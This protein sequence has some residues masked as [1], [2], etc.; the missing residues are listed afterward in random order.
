[1]LSS[2]KTL[3]DKGFRI[4]SINPLILNEYIKHDYQSQEEI[5]NGLI[6]QLIEI[7]DYIYELSK[8][9]KIVKVGFLEKNLIQIYKPKVI[10]SLDTVQC[11]ATSRN[12]AINTKGDVFPCDLF[13]YK[14]KYKLGNLLENKLESNDLFEKH[15]IKNLK[16]EY[17]VAC[18]NCYMRY[19]CKGKC[20]YKVINN[21]ESVENNIQCEYIKYQLFSTLY[22]LTKICNKYE[23]P[24]VKNWPLIEEE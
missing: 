11:S 9:G 14:Y 6:S 4:F 17:M 16:K 3:I 15:N 24:F 10:L 13:L 12:V 22:F 20:P 21:Q 18:K 19:M 1:M 2:L 8:V 23:H 5:Y 7:V